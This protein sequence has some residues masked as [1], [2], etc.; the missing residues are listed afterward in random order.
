ML[1]DAELARYARQILLPGFDI[2]GQERLKA[3]R[4]LVLGLGGL[5]SPAA[6][7]LAGAGVGTLVL[8]DGDV[9]ETSNLQ[10]QLC[11]TE[12]DCG[13]NKAGSAAAAIAARNPEVAVEVI[14]RTLDEPGLDG[15][16]PG[17]DLVLDCTDNYPVR[18]ALNRASLRHG[19]P[20]VSAAAVRT[21]AQVAVLDPAGGGPCY[22]CL[23]PQGG[24]DTA[25]SCSQS[26]VLG[27]VVGVA[28]SLQALEAIKLLSACAE[29]LRN[30]LL[31]MDLATLDFQRLRVG[32]RADCPDCG[33]R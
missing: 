32:R 6:L 27:P 22:R 7:Y 1:S 24:A 19:V 9:V 20:V 21:E 31:I 14:A 3:A 2:A 17:L 30:H 18:Y 16:L 10:R 26:G 8:A 5:G 12:A 4:V 15:L 11:H 13:R 28:G 25:L 23:Y 33:D 29:P